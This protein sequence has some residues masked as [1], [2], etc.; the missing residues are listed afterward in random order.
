MDQFE[1]L[2]GIKG[3]TLINFV[4]EDMKDQGYRI[5]IDF[6]CTCLRYDEYFFISVVT[7]IRGLYTWEGDIKLRQSM[8]Q[9]FEIKSRPLLGACSNE[10]QVD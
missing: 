4:K 7:S 8:G 1:G 6:S 10:L 3:E 2:N 9:W 5:R